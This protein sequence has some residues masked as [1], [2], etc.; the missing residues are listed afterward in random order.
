SAPAPTASGTAPAPPSP[1]PV[2]DP[3]FSFP[4]AV[5]GGPR[6]GTGLALATQV[7]RGTSAAARSSARE[8]AAAAETAAA[9][10]ARRRRDKSK[11]QGRGVEYMDMN[12]TARFEEPAP[13]PTASHRGAGP[14]GF[15]GTV[16]KTG[17]TASG[18]ATLRRD[19][20]LF[21]GAQAPMVPNTWDPEH[22]R[23]G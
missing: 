12:A 9:R 18:L 2:G 1:P 5:G 19:D 20:D 22:G 13:D 15:A 10:Q 14:M 7:R 16:I 17:A 6:L 23:Q 3:G 11:Q 4:Y 21:E 8:Q